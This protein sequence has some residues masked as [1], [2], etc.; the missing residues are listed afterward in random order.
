VN[1]E[2]SEGFFMSEIA[3]LFEA[4]SHPAR[5]RILELL[6]NSPMGFSELKRNLEVKSSGNL[7]HHVKKM[8]EL[9]SID[10]QGLYTLTEKGREAL[11]GI[12]TIKSNIKANRSEPSTQSKK[13]FSALVML[14]GGFIIVLILSISLVIMSKPFDVA[15][16]GVVIGLLGAVAGCMVGMKGVKSTITSEGK[17]L[18]PLTYWPSMGMRW[19][20]RDWALNILFFASWFVLLFDVISIQVFLPWSGDYMLRILWYASS[21]LSLIVFFTS[22]MA[23]SRRII[24][25]ATKLLQKTN[26][27][28]LPSS[29]RRARY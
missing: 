6:E 27:P 24:T 29:D 21:L 12:R 19:E 23:V 26:Q 14:V 15:F 3:Q 9:V 8:S 4:V 20:L 11:K 7:D 13:A 28:I 5:I 22:A 18:G 10:H 1:E 16:L 25:K 2:I 17:S